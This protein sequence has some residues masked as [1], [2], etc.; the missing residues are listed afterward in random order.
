MN[1]WLI[2][3]KGD[4]FPKLLRIGLRSKI[5]PRFDMGAKLPKST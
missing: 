5:L 1:L 4:N 3:L 2:G